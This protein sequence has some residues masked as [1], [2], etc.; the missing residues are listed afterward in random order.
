MICLHTYSKTPLLDFIFDPNLEFRTSQALFVYSGSLPPGVQ[1][2]SHPYPY[3]K[4]KHQLQKVP[5]NM[6][7]ADIFIT[8]MRPY[9]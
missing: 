6:R 5:K 9:K 7:R 1:L 4:K 3:D 8:Y 2:Q